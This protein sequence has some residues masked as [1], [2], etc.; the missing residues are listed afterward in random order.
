MRVITVMLGPALEGVLSMDAYSTELG[1]DFYAGP[2]PVLIAAD[3]EASK[4]R[5]AAIMEAAGLRV[6][7]TLD[8]NSAPERIQ[9][10]PAISALWVELERD[11]GPSMDRLLA[12]V[13]G[14][15]RDGRYSA[16]VA[17][18]GAVVD[19]LARQIDDAAVEL[20]IDGSDSERAA[21][22]ALAVSRTARAD[23]LSDVAS[24][25]NSVRLRQLSDE[26]SRIAATL[27]RLSSG[28]TQQSRPVAPQ[29]EE[30]VPEVS[31]ETVRAVIRARRLRERYFSAELFADPAWDMLLD[32]LQAEIAQL[33]V[34][35][36]SLCIAASVPST[37]ALRWLKTM[38]QQGIFMRRADPH[39]GRR[40][41]V[42]LSPEASIAMRR[43]FA[44][45]GPVPVI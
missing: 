26:V 22:L 20:V 6:G 35:V 24:D 43:Y 32:L 39:D 17:A 44:E 27:A 8:L 29:P 9:L 28:P 45:V 3:S 5:A 18:P 14:D 13:N 37:T 21:A 10:Q 31:A 23:R 30:E 34:P 7:V 25:Q 12:Q 11:S 38:T 2:A 4:R 40:I 1:S 19:P 41:F 42:E 36:S 15:A 16:V 33:R